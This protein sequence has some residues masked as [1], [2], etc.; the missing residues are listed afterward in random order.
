MVQLRTIGPLLIA[1]AVLIFPRLGMA[2]EAATGHY[3]PGAMSDFID[4]LPDR[5]SSTFLYANGF[6]YYDGSASPSKTLDFGGLLTSDAKATIYADTSLFLYQAPWKFLGGQYAVELLVPYVWLDVEG[7]VARNG[8]FKTQTVHLNDAANA[9]GDIEMFPFMYGWK[10]GDFKWQTQFGI[11]VPSG[12]FDKGDLANVGRNY[13][14]FEPALAFSYLSSKIG[15]EF[16]TFVGF[17]FNTKNDATDYQT[18]DQF[19]V[20]G[21]VAQH[22]PLF[23]G[24]AGAGVNGYFYQQI[25]GD[26]GSGAKL[27]SFE[28]MTTGV[29]PV[30]S[31]AHRIGN[32]DVAGEAKWLPEFDVTNRLNGNTVWVKFG[33]TWGPNPSRALE[34]M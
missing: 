7:D 13:W 26:S 20:D 6:T 33:V 19:H 21:T 5:D 25:T 22:L 9:F 3:I 27:G 14:T 11:Y 24:F 29:G 16:T 28:A 31:Y 15:T 10:Y 17:D 8:K 2:E 23:G 1:S 18:G 30:A 32:F 34:G 12:G 4:M